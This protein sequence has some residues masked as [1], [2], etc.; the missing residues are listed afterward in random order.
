MAAAMPLTAALVWGQRGPDPLSGFDIPAAMARPGFSPA[1]FAD[2]FGGYRMG[3][4][5][6]LDSRLGFSARLYRMVLRQLQNGRVDQQAGADG[7]V[8]WAG[9]AGLLTAAIDSGAVNQS[10]DQ[11]LLTVR[12]NAEGLYRFTTGQ[13][14]LPVCA[15][16]AE[17]ACDPS[18]FNNLELNASFDGRRLAGAGARF[19]A[20]NSRDLRSP[21]TA[22]LGPIGTAKT[23]RV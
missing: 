15:G 8:K 12:G 10:F 19:V 21:C 11:N 22:R 5:R 3:F 13:E 2:V 1:A 20:I 14:L 23:R 6:Y 18:P 7:A 9:I 16:A 4:V 17:A